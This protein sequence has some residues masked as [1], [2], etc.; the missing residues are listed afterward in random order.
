MRDIV[1]VLLTIGFFALAGAY[2]GACARIVGRDDLV[3]VPSEEDEL[4][5]EVLG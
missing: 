5:Q 1:F 2:I 4:V 3:E